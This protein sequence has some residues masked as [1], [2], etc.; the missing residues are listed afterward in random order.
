MFTA[1][2]AF[3]EAFGN[4]LAPALVL[5]LALLLTKPWHLR[6]GAAA[7]GC[8]AALPELAFATSATEVALGLLGAVVAMLL[9][10]E[11]M[12][13]LVLDTLN[14]GI[15]WLW[16]FSDRLITL[17]TVPHAAISAELSRDAAVRIRIFATRLIFANI[18]LILGL[19]IPAAML[20]AEREQR[21]TTERARTLERRAVDVARFMR[22]YSSV[23]F[24]RGMVFIAEVIAHDI[25]TLC[26]AA[27]HAESACHDAILR[28]F[29]AVD[30]IAESRD[31]QKALGGVRLA[32]IKLA[33]IYLVQGAVSLAKRVADDMAGEDH[34]RLRGMWQKLVK[35]DDR[36][37]LQPG[38]KYYEWEGKGVPLRIEIGPK[39]LEKGMLCLVRRFVADIAGESAEDQRKRKKSFVPR[40]EALASVRGIL[41][42]MQAELFARARTMQAAR[43]RVI[44][45]LADFERFFTQDGGGFA[46][47]HWAGGPEHEDEMGKRFETTIRCIPLPDQIPEA[48][49]GDGVCI[50]TGKPS[51][52][53]VV[54]AKAY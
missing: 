25:G 28:Y 13:H 12:L 41:D 21:E 34:R 45:N 38:A 18:G 5:C 39:D 15:L 36:D 50:L 11:V 48:A 19:I 42:G 3:A 40:A 17:V 24:K 9:Y 49:R 20:K 16:P 54:M 10:A 2:A 35:L 22:Y 46:W 32:Q 6:S 53:R 51:A 30:D 37:N 27:F 23:A 1:P 26:A 33:T 4:P 31:Q 43:T 29:L 47:V 7:L 8:L 44:D 14:G 52:Q